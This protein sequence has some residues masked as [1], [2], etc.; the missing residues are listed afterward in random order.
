MVP[1]IYTL[2]GCSNM[3][4]NRLISAEYQKK[5]FVN[6]KKKKK[7]KML[8]MIKK[9]PIMILAHVHISNSLYN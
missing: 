5:L 7:K 4:K 9:E 1:G 8:K 2:Q 6:A 3:N